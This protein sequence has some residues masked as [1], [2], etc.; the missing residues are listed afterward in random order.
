MSRWSACRVLLEVLS[1]PCLGQSKA[2]AHGLS[3]GHLH[4]R[5]IAS[6]SPCF[7]T[8]SVAQRRAQSGYLRTSL[9]VGLILCLAGCDGA[10]TRVADPDKSPSS[11]AAAARQHLVGSC[12]G[13]GSP[14][15][16]LNVGL[17]GTPDL[18]DSLVAAV[19]P[20][21]RVCAYARAGLG[22]SPSLPADAAD[23]AAGSQADQ[24]LATLEG[25]GVAGPYVMLGWSYGGIVTQAFANRH[26]DTI[27]GVVF[28]DSSVVEQF[29]DADWAFIDWT[30]AGRAIDTI[31]T[32]DDVAGLELDSR[33][34][35]VLTQDQL[36]RPLA[37]S[38]LHD[39]DRLARLSNN[40]IH[41][42]AVGSGHE[43]HKDATALVAE[44]IKEVVA[45][46]RSGDSLAPCDGRFAAAGGR[47][48]Q[49]E[50]PD[51]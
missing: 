49:R 38:W 10:E 48:R 23:P 30:E 6:S 33:P 20:T 8:A 47:C 39:Q 41:V 18:F 46:V 29:T 51:R 4:E 13:T 17:G 14:A 40:S 16:I 28:E 2:S 43:I 7:E 45:A 32:T 36:P 15:V 9:A 27:V 25:D 42:I 5:A 21:T 44:A 34:L 24:L 3:P 22:G 31:A 19:S 26:P 35:V 50:A 11:P 37:R 1:I 12:T